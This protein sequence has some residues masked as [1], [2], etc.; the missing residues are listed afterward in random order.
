MIIDQLGFVILAEIGGKGRKAQ[1]REEGIFDRPEQR[2]F[3]LGQGRQNEFHLH[4]M[5]L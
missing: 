1:R 2:A 5:G 3:R 4:G